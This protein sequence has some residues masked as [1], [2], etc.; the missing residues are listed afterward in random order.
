MFRICCWSDSQVPSAKFAGCIMF[1]WLS[2]LHLNGNSGVIKCGSYFNNSFHHSYWINYI[3]L[4]QVN[5]WDLEMCWHCQKVRRGKK[6]CSQTTMEVLFFCFFCL[7]VFSFF[8]TTVVVWTVVVW[9]EIRNMGR[10]SQGY[11]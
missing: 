8:D 4:A 10:E 3:A 5:C 11:D 9:R 1:Y 2:Y 6:C 7:F